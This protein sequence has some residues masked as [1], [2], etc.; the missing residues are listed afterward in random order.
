MYSRVSSL[1]ILVIVAFTIAGCKA[2]PTPTG[3]TFVTPPPSATATLFQP[4][5][6]LTPALP[7]PTPEPLAATV[8]GEGVSLSE[9]NAEIQRL[10]A[11]LKDTGKTLQPADLQK[12]ALDELI[13]ETLLAAA[14]VKA[15]YKLDD[16]AFQKHLDD[17]TAQAGG[18][19]S[20]AD[21][22]KNNYYDTDSLKK[23]LRRSMAAAWE[24]DQ[25]TASAPTTADQVH[26]RQMLLL[27]SDTANLYYQRLQAG[28]DFAT[29][30]YVVD[31]DTGGD[32]GWFPKGYLLLPEIEKAAFDLQP[33]QYSPI[34]KTAYGY[35]IIFVIERDSQHP[36][37]T[38]ARRVLQQQLLANWLK[39]QNSSA[40][41]EILVPSP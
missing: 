10:Q 19:Q 22:M 28:T 35:Q 25:L 2:T 29:L 1:A 30:A 32:L 39:E 37:S 18:T 31:P 13:N 3:P 20:L 34:I 5:L 6:T 36:L 41:I 24:R 11:S 12:Q 23:A 7:T 4:T 9:Y 14:A 33:G 26:A 38:D 8:N 27:D 16:A 15:G 40:K 21:W 17:L